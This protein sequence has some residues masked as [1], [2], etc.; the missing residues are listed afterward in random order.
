MTKKIDNSKYIQ[1][2]GSYI[3]TFDNSATDPQFLVEIIGGSGIGLWYYPTLRQVVLRNQ[4]GNNIQWMASGQISDA[5]GSLS[6]FSFPIAAT[7]SNPL[8]SIF[9]M[10]E[11][12]FSFSGQYDADFSATV[13]NSFI[14]LKDVEIKYVNA[15]TIYL[16]H[17]DLN[18]T[19]LESVN[20]IQISPISQTI[21]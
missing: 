15:Q 5:N 4:S 10:Q 3:R 18:N 1:A 19:C 20:T 8:I 9:S 21:Y 13:T 7:P 11:G 2:D 16:Y 14:T 17:F 6:E 12:Y